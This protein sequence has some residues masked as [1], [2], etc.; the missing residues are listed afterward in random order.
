[1]AA[2]LAA[3]ERQ[4]RSVSQQMQNRPDPPGRLSALN[5]SHIK[6]IF[7]GAFVR[8]GRALK[9][10]FRRFPARAVELIRTTT[11]SLDVM[12]AASPPSAL[13]PAV[14]QLV[15]LGFDAGQARGNG[16]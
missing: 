8:T 3:V 13:P 6:S 9:G 14:Q 1:M 12:P 4:K 11:G 16:R 5:I 2:E 7:Y 10:P 15:D